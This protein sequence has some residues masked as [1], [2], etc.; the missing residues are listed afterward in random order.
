MNGNIAQ[1]SLSFPF[2]LW[3]NAHKATPQPLEE[4]RGVM[5]ASIDDGVPLAVVGEV[6]AL[7]HGVEGEHHHLHAGDA[8]G[9]DELQGFGPQVPQLELIAE[10]DRKS[11]V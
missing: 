5:G 4:G 8:A 1:F 6:G 9:T 10:E 7:P 11:V 2:L 3:Y